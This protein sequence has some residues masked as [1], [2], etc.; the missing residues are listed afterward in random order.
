[1]PGI[2]HN[3]SLGS[4]SKEAA[5]V[6]AFWRSSVHSLLDACIR[7]DEVLEICE[8]DDVRRDRFIS[9]LVNG[10]VLTRRRGGSASVARSS[11]SCALS[12]RMPISCGARRSPVVEP[13]Y[14]VLYQLCVFYK[15][16]PAKEPQ[17]LQRFQ[18]ASGLLG[19]VIS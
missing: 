4:I 13:E 12:G 9:G 19:R 17:K 15:K 14:S 2:G 10:G 3:R 5:R 11:L 6:S 1:M 16:I 18:R 7:I 8:G